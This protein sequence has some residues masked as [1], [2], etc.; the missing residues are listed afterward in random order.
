MGRALI[1]SRVEAWRTKSV[2]QNDKWVVQK[3]DVYLGIVLRCE[4]SDHETEQ[5]FVFLIMDEQG[6]LHVHTHRT[7]RVR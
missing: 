5:E 2:R 1:G 7:V 4:L 3:V 6:F